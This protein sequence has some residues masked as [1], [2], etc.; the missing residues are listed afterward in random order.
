M[1]LGRTLR[2]IRIDRFP[3]RL[4]P[5]HR[6][7]TMAPTATL[8]KDVRPIIISG[9][10]GVGKGTLY[11]MLQDAHPNVFETSISH[12]TRGARPGEAHEKDY[13]FVKMEDFEDLISKEGEMIE[14][15]TKEG[16]VVILDI[17]MEGVKQIK[18]TTL[19]ARY[20]FIAPPNFEALESR[21]RGRGTEKEESIQKRLQQAKAE[22]EYSKVEGVHDKIIVNDDKQKA[23]EELN[24]FVFGKE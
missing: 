17:E 7:Y 22:L 23:F 11:K 16:K 3:K 24:E 9:P 1:L 12:T 20:V 19:D 2:A 21:L 13:Y 5:L 8:P 10:S 18:N 6:S 15:L 14:R 4:H